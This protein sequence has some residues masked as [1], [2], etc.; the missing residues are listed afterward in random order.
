M[1]HPAQAIDKARIAQKLARAEVAVSEK[2]F[3][4]GSMARILLTHQTEILVEL[5]GMKAALVLSIMI[6]APVGH[7]ANAAQ[8][9]SSDYSDVSVISV[10]PRTSAVRPFVM[11]IFT[12]EQ[13]QRVAA[14]T[15]KK[16]A[17]LTK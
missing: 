12:K 14:A 10:T 9:D 13:R 17:L 6:L 5:C 11:A 15:L 2:K 16:T 7:A 8:F 3:L 1:R 4:P